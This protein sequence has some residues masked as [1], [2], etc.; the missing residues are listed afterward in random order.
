MDCYNFCEEMLGC[1]G[2]YLYENEKPGKEQSNYPD[3]D[4]S[5]QPPLYNLMSRYGGREF[6]TSQQGARARYYLNYRLNNELYGNV[7]EEIGEY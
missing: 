2:K 3:C 7:L 4:S 6:I 1:S 5:Y